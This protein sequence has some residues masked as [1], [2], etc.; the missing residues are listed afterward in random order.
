MKS[1]IPEHVIE[2]V[3][4]DILKQIEYIKN[5]EWHKGISQE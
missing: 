2:K 5:F 4:N 3:R 1:I